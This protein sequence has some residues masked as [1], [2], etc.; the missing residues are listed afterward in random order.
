MK[1]SLLIPTTSDRE[2]YFADIMSQLCKQ[3]KILSDKTHEDYWRHVEIL[4]DPRDKSF[5]IGEKRNSLLFAATGEYLNFLDSDDQV[6]DDYLETVL[7]GI[8]NKPDCL[9]L[10]GIMTTDGERPEIFEHSLK[11]QE[12][13]E[14]KNEIKY[15]RYP[16]HLNCI[17][18]DIAKQIKFPEKNFGED[19]AWSKSL[20]ESGVLKNEF[21]I[22]KVM[23]YY[24]YMTKK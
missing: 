8:E 11:Y 21:Y 6:S 3:V 5:T 17:R 1:L 22:D 15:E 9:S 4:K 19:H 2:N 24:K 14:T 16:N 23:Y 18:S 13:R 20:H 10:R 12:W 7:E